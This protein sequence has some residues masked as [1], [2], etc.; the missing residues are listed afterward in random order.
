[1][2]R[3]A[4][5]FIPAENRRMN[6]PDRSTA[7]LRKRL[8]FYFAAALLVLVL[9]LTTAIT[10]TLFGSLKEAESHSLAHMAEMRSIAVS[11]WCRRVKDVARQI[12][13]R[14]RI[15][16]ELEKFN[17]GQTTLA[18]LIDFTRP[19]LQDA[20][21]LSEEIAGIIRLDVQN[22]IVARCGF[23]AKLPLN[24]GDISQYVFDHTVISEPFA[25]DDRTLAVV[26]APILNR[27]GQRQGTDLVII[28][29]EPLRKIIGNPN[30]MGKTTEVIIGYRSGESISPLLP[31]DEQ[32]ENFFFPPN[33]PLSA[34]QSGISKAISGEM[35][36]VHA[37]ERAVAHYPIEES[38]WGV[39]VTQNESELYAPL[40]AKM[41]A[42]GGLSFFTYCIILFG[43]WFVMRPLAGRI[44]LH[45]DELERK[46]QEKTESLEREIGDRKRAEKEK[47]EI[48][49]ELREAMQEIRALSGLLPICSNCKKIRD[50]KG[51]WNQIES[52]I[53][54]HSEAEFSH[55]ICPECARKLYPDLD[56]HDA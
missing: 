9:G 12:T 20:M 48:I 40:Y 1:M 14:S 15:R 56:I 38:D 55:G 17:N 54:S 28:D 7:Q 27:N 46:I 19:K 33:T 30:E 32:A 44:L 52:Y 11:E 24:G 45:T 41:A 35:G 49:A 22:R 51:Y 10:I 8:F 4:A 47:E 37:G 2:P 53:Q 6:N 36:F 3:N 43:F 26:S 13:S 34:V 31:P 39:A 16:Q 25:I 42:L 21:E 18:E 29:M 50:D 23:E 5:P